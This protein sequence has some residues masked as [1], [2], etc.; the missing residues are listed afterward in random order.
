M[1][2]TLGVELHDPGFDCDPPC[3]RTNPTISAPGAPTLQRRRDRYAA[4]TRIEPA[5]CL[6]G[7][8]QP[9][10]IAARPTNSLL[11]LSREGGRTSADT[12]HAASGRSL[13]TLVA[14]LARTESKV[15]VVVCHGMT[16]GSRAQAC[17]RQTARVGA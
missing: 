11:D 3:P 5:A 12:A 14:D 4:A 6:P 17:K 16:I 2:I 8:A 7:P 10:R 1:G 15:V 9:G 13:T